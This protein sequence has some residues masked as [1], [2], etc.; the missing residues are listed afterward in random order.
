MEKKKYTGTGLPMPL[1]CP[2]SPDACVESHTCQKR[3]TIGAN[4]TY[5]VRTFENLPDGTHATQMIS[6]LIGFSC[7]FFCGS[8]DSVDLH[9]LA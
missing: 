5:Y 9:L 3:P 2:C 8:G 7:G 4:E 1:L 6:A